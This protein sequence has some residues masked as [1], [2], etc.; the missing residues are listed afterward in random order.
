MFEGTI[1]SFSNQ[2]KFL[3]SIKE[4]FKNITIKDQ[5]YENENFDKISIYKENNLDKYLSQEKLDI[6]LKDKF[7]ICS[8]LGTT[9]LE[10]MANDIPHVLFYRPGEFNPS[11]K[12]SNYLKKMK[13]YKFIYYNPINAANFIINNKNE[14]KKLWEKKEFVNLRDE[15]REEFCNNPKNWE[16]NFFEALNL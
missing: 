8:Y 5:S 11:I 4:S 15:F 3:N 2:I 6:L 13:E 7:P 1:K 12:A 10:L 14:I 9:F 16:T